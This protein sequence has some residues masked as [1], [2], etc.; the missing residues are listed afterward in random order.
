MSV[1]L[2]MAGAVAAVAGGIMVAFGVPVK[3]FSF[4][5]TLILAGTTAIVGGLIVV[6]LGVVVAQLQR[7]AEMLGA[8]PLARSTRPL[9]QF[10]QP[11]TGARL[12]Q[13]PGRIPFP[14]KPKSEP[15]RD[16]HGL[17]QQIAV[18]PPFDSMHVEQLEQNFA[19]M[20][21]NP[22]EPAIADAGEAPLSPRQIPIGAPPRAGMEF[23]EPTRSAPLAP[24]VGVNGSPAE[25]RQPAFDTAWRPVPTSV[26]PPQPAYFDAMWPAES[27][28]S[29]SA[30]GEGEEAKPSR[31]ESIPR[32]SSPPDAKRATPEAARQNTASEVRAIAILKSGVVDGMG[33]TLYVDGSIEAELPQGTLRFASISELRSHL[34][35][36]P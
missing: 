15:A 14:S 16:Q 31:A 32:M 19:P 2:F 6:G 26:R 28:G 20:L 8:R 9:D 22:E 3:E 1:L 30:N 34:E 7:I 21:R 27:R 25:S 18:P 4:G 24:P 35:K 36:N 23:S 12:G 29:K 17:D 33:Y 10:E 13:G 11:P 5:N